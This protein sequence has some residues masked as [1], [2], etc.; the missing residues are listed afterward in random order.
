MSNHKNAG[1]NDQN[2]GLMAKA[3]LKDQKAGLKGQIA[4]RNGQMPAW[5]LPGMVKCWPGC[6]TVQYYLK[7][8][9]NTVVPY[10]TLVSNNSTPNST[11]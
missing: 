10:T 3:G 8:P 1:L 9:D 11:Q 7:V 4:G 6:Q 2:A 5:I